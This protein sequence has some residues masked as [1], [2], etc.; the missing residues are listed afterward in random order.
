MRIQK[1]FPIAVA[2][3]LFAC[4]KDKDTPATVQGTPC[5]YTVGQWSAWTNG[6][7]TRTVTAAPA[8]CVG[9]LPAT[10]ENHTC[11]A[12]NRGWITVRNYSTNPY[13]VT[14]TGPSSWPPFDLP[15]GMMQDSIPL[16]PGNYGLYS[17]QLSGYVL[18]PSEFNG[19]I[20]LP[21]CNERIWSFP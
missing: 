15:G 12:L 21:L 19:N 8:G 7:R 17:L 10:T 3:L 18:F 9:T 20:S 5:T 6:V 2:C 13:R 14:I 16:G 4:S 11:I 1:L